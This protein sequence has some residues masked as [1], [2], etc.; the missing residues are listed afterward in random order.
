MEF[1]IL[2]RFNGLENIPKDPCNADDIGTSLFL[3][4]N[5]GPRISDKNGRLRSQG[6]YVAARVL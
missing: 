3:T 6:W 1:N 4:G 2:Q 5:M